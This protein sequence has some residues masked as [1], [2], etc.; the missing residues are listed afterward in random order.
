MG[1]VPRGTSLQHA[2]MAW[3][4]QAD[5][6]RSQPNESRVAYPAAGLGGPCVHVDQIAPSSLS[7]CRTSL[8][9]IRRTHT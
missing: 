5:A 6:C 2:G 7:T 9:A 4:V 1:L 8:A 3:A